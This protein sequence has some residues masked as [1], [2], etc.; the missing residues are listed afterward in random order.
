MVEDASAPDGSKVLAQ[1]SSQGPKKMFNLCVANYTHYQDVEINVWFKAVEG[2]IDQ[3]GGPVWRYSD[4]NNYYVA[5]MN[6]LED[7]V[8]VYRVVE[9]KR[10]MLKSAD[11]TAAAGTWHSLRVVHRGDHIQCFL[12]GSL[13]L[14]VTD[15]TFKGPGKTG[16]WT[17]ADAVTSFDDFWVSK[18]D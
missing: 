13:T 16:L 17:K 8:R 15:D 11:V 18:P 5:R 7:N 14:E 10:K 3:G 6:P 9:G 2:R 12:N 4:S 1:T